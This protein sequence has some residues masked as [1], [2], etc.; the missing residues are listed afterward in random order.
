MKLGTLIQN[1]MSYYCTKFEGVTQWA[2]EGVKENP[3]FLPLNDPNIDKMNIY[4]PKVPLLSIFHQF[5]FIKYDILIKV[6]KSWGTLG[7]ASD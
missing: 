2:S 4:L 1:I 6:D 5:L 7:A 3:H